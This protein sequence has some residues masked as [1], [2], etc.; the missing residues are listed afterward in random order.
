MALQN[1]SWCISV[2]SI[3]LTVNLL[4]IILYYY[5]CVYFYKEPPILQKSSTTEMNGSSLA[6]KEDE[7]FMQNPPN[8]KFKQKI[9]LQK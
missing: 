3:P 4:I 8:I 5:Y 2:N 7:K 6:N 9:M 1:E